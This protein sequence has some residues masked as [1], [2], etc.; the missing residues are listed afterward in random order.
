MTIERKFISD[1]H[2]G[3]RPSAIQ[4]VC[5][6]CTEELADNRPFVLYE[7]PKVTP[8]A[9]DEADFW[10]ESHNRLTGGKH[11]IVIYEFLNSAY[12]PE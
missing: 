6:G 4:A 12:R 9:L 11:H 7:A 3:V 8:D 5:K 10:A 1:G 2:L